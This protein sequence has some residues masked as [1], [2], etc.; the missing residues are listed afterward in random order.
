MGRKDD[1]DAA[2]RSPSSADRGAPE[3]ETTAEDGADSVPL[4]DGQPDGHALGIWARDAGHQQP[5]GRRSSRD[6]DVLAGC[7]ENCLWQATVRFRN[8][9]V[10]ATSQCIMWPSI[11]RMAATVLAPPP[12]GLASR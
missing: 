12:A 9:S 4:Y 1:C 3:T 7:R 8:G 11:L 6:Y 10:D 2:H 5:C